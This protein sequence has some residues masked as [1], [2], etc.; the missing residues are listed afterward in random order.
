MPLFMITLIPYYQFMKPI[1]DKRLFL[2]NMEPLRCLCCLF[3][4][5]ENR[6]GEF[7]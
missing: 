7:Y 2:R 1:L 5:A 3:F 4:S 6:I